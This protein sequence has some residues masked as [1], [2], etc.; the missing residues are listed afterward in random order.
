MGWS[1]GDW[2]PARDL[3]DGLAGQGEH[4]GLAGILVAGDQHRLGLFFQSG[5]GNLLQA[6]IPG[7]LNGGVQTAQV[8]IGGDYQGPAIVDGI[9]GW[10]VRG[11]RLVFF[12]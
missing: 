6:P 8:H 3:G 4:P 11:R 2:R 1:V 7:R 5:N 12:F 10:D 9:P